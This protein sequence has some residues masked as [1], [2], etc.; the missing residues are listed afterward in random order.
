MP[1]KLTNCVKKVRRSGKS[2]SSAWAICIKSTGLKPHKK[3][4]KK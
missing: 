1:R 2:K 4:K 3:G